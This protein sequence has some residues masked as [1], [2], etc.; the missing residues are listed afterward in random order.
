MDDHGWVRVEELIAAANANGKKYTPA[1][2]QEIVAADEK[3]RYALSDDGHMIRANQ[4]HTVKVDL[5]LESAKPPAN[6]YH[7]TAERFLNSILEQ[8][9]KPGRRHHVHLS[10]DYHTAVSV[11]SRYGEPVILKINAT[12]MDQDGFDFYLSSNKIWL[13]EFVK[14]EYIQM[15]PTEE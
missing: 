9:L 15:V 11:G 6:L 2:I 1:I 5:Q 13:T 10:T 8:G 7:G 3:Q 14:P 4:G 12:Q